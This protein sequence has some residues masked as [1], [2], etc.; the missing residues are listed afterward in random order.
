MTPGP[1]PA[2]MLSLEPSSCHHRLANGVVKC[3]EFAFWILRRRSA[4]LAVIKYPTPCRVEP[5]NERA[6]LRS[7]ALSAAFLVGEAFKRPRLRS[8][9]FPRE[10]ACEKT[11]GQAG[12]PDVWE[13]AGLQS[14]TASP[15]VTYY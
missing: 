11:C 13:F 3:R 6:P 4:G 2:I 14:Q 12:K 8:R 15:S 9:L 10:W 5:L 1:M 7:A